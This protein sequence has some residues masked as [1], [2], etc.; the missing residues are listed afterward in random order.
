MNLLAFAVWAVLF[1]ADDTGMSPDNRP[2]EF[3]V[4]VEGGY[5]NGWHQVGLEGAVGMKARVTVIRL[6]HDERWQAGVSAY[7]GG[8]DKEAGLMIYTG[9]AGEPVPGLPLLVYAT[10]SQQEA[11]IRHMFKMAANPAQPFD[12]ELRWTTDGI[13]CATFRQ[14]GKF[15]SRAVNLGRMPEELKLTGSTGA[16]RFEGVELLAPAAGRDRAEEDLAVK[17]NCVPVS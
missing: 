3:T 13:V 15:E 1:A 6:G 4:D 2:P 11:K 14:G 8:G 16:F 5:Y 10:E 17:A 12:I 7:V 9:Y